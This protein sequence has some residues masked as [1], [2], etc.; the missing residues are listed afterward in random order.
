MIRVSWYNIIINM[1]VNVILN[2]PKYIN[3]YS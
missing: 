3:E 1:V 2:M